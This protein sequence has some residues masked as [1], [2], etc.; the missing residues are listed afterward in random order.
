MSAAADGPARGHTAATLYEAA[1]AAEGPGR[2]AMDVGIR[3]VWPG[4]RV[5]AP[6]FTVQGAGGDNLALQH[7]ILEAP[8]GAVLVAD[9]NG[10][11]WGHWGEVLAVASQVRHI[12]GLVIDG[13]VR[14]T[15]EMAELDFPVFSRHVN[16]RG[17]R[18]LFR[19]A[20]GIPVQVGAV[21]V[22]TGD[23][24][25]ADADGVVVLPQHVADRVLDTADER[26][27]KEADIIRRLK[28]GESSLDIYGLAEAGR[29]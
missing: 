2:Y 11:D 17:T 28:A 7:A 21:T 13:G 1:V 9:V 19:G 25:V 23:L 20:L 27:A 15:V 18:K 14:D 8:A 10:A 16:V 6:A 26:V 29:G 22:H 5:A 4:A 12:A 3:A 24:V